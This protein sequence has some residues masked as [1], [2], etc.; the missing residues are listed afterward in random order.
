MFG[1]SVTLADICI[2]PQ[3]YNAL[4]FRCDLTPYPTL[5]AICRHLES[6]PPFIK[7]S[8]EVQPDSE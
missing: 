6:L 3:M 5:R 8:P 4:R 2:V 7:A 1:T